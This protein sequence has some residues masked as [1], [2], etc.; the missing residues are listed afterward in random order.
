MGGR[1]DG[2][3]L[4]LGL[5]LGLGSGG[6]KRELDELPHLLRDE[7]LETWIQHVTAGR[8]ASGPGPAAATKVVRDG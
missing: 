2:A 8:D 5:Q 7:L 3:A 6:D 4:E 1:G